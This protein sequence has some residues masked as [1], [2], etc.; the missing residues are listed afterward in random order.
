M[1]FDVLVLSGYLTKEQRKILTTQFGSYTNA[2]AALIAAGFFTS[3]GLAA[4]ISELFREKIYKVQDFNYQAP[5]LLKLRN[6]VLKHQALPL[7]MINNK[8]LLAVSDPTNTDAQNDFRFN[9]ELNVQMLLV[10]HENLTTAIRKLYGKEA[11]PNAAGMSNIAVQ[12][13]DL[14]LLDDLDIVEGSESLSDKAPLSRY[15]HQVLLDA[16][17]RQVSDIHFE[18]FDG[19]YQI[20][21]RQDGILQKYGEPPAG[22]AR[23]I[24][25]RLKILGKLNIAERRLPQDGRLNLKLSEQYDVDM[26]IST[27]PTLWGEKVVLRILDNSNTPLDFDKLGF[28]TQQKL[29]FKKALSSPQGLIL[30][31]GPTGS[32][33]TVS[34]YTGLNYLNTPETNISTAEDPIEINLLG[35]NQVNVNSDIGFNFATALRAFLRQDPDVIML[36]EIRDLETA[37]I[38]IKA[39]QTGH[40]VLST[41]H[42]NSAAKTITRLTNM[43]V[44]PYNI[45]SSLLLVVAQRLARRL[46]THCKE[47]HP[48][49]EIAQEIL[50]TY[51]QLKEQPLFRANKN[52]CAHCNNGYLGRIGIYE[53][54]SATST[55]NDVILKKANDHYEL[56][57][58]ACGEGMKTLQGDGIDK[59]CEGI[60]SLD[61]LLR[62]VYFS[63]DL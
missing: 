10:E 59:V 56:E 44:A 55:L 35:I 9:T 18:P 57:N 4:T 24:A 31:T 49:N 26:R 2:P 30:I 6:L 62:V 29:I 52:G 34:L 20:R 42:T 53:M 36:G 63:V 47:V 7:T 16:I 40:L 33:K 8:L 32:G 45:A 14:N 1:L 37:E 19:Y 3:A 51:P 15:L 43:G 54:M 23:R 46:C 17:G 13:S 50:E 41:L 48:L 58:T 5:E 28:S 61:E 39:A 27:L 25:A 12:E 21:F 60:I 38:A 11:V 22:I